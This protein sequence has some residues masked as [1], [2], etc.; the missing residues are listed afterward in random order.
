MAKAGW[1]TLLRLACQASLAG[2]ATGTHI[3]GLTNDVHMGPTS[4]EIVTPGHVR[5][6]TAI[7][8]KQYIQPGKIS[9]AYTG[10][11]TPLTPTVFQWLMASLMNDT[12][13]EEAAAVTHVP[14]TSATPVVWYT[15]Q[16]YMEATAGGT[17]VEGCT[18]N[19]IAIDC[20]ADGMATLSF[21]FMGMIERTG[22]VAVSTSTILADTGLL[23][24]DAV[25]TWDGHAVNQIAMSY[26]LTN[27]AFFDHQAAQSP[28]SIILGPFG[29]TGSLTLEW[30]EAIATSGLDV[31]A[32]QGINVPSGNEYELVC[33]WG[34]SAAAGYI[35][36]T[37]MV[38]ISGQP[39]QS[40]TNGY[41]TLTVPWTMT[42]G[43]LTPSF[44]SRATIPFDFVV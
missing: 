12:S 28:V 22:A 19:H 38:Y 2:E 5:D 26:D 31:D 16:K 25:V 34:S 29:C 3:L 4:P 30:D 24:K 18:V 6:G 20:P 15:F 21:D 43:T 33:T 36:L 41:Q 13:E 9:P 1:N 7:V 10:L 23:T 37:G 17:E 11:Q 42:S 35:M 44:A 32:R 14:Y 39:T 8:K 40:E 27:G